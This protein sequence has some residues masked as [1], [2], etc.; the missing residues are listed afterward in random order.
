MPKPLAFDTLTKHLDASAKEALC[1]EAARL[2]RD[3]YG[4]A[5]VIWTPDEMGDTNPE[6]L[7]DVMIERGADFIDFP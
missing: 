5:V 7:Q 4:Y 1:Y 3:D 2:L 6:R